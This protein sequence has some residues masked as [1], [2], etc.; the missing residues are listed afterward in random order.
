MQLDRKSG[1]DD[2]LIPQSWI[3]TIF[4]QYVFQLAFPVLL[5][6]QLLLPFEFLKVL[7][8][9]LLDLR[10]LVEEPRPFLLESLL[11]CPNKTNRDVVFSRD[12]LDRLLSSQRFRGYLQLEI[13]GKCPLFPS[14]TSTIRMLHIVDNSIRIFLIPLIPPVR[15]SVLV[16]C[17]PLWLY[18]SKPMAST[19][20]KSCFARACSTYRVISLHNLVSCSPTC[21]ATWLTGICWSIVSNTASIRR[22]NPLAD[23]AHGTCTCFTRCLSHVIQGKRAWI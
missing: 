13:T 1:S 10:F 17:C 11:P 9:L 4:Q 12:R 14:H 21:F 18:S 8:K 16:Y 15:D 23:L 2:L 22:V 7:F 20:L 19:V 6:Q 3:F 5:K